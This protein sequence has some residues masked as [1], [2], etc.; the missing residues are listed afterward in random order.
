LNFSDL[1]ATSKVETSAR[2]QFF[3]APELS[4]AAGEAHMM[5]GS[6]TATHKEHMTCHWLSG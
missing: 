4:M 3:T 5:A 6:P 2:E 1:D